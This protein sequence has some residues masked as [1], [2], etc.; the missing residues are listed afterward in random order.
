MCNEMCSSEGFSACGVSVKC[1]AARP[2]PRDADTQGQPLS[3]RGDAGL[4]VL[5]AGQ[6]ENTATATAPLG[7]RQVRKGQKAL[8]CHP[9]KEL[10]DILLLGSRELILELLVH[11]HTQG[12]AL[13]FPLWMMFPPLLV[14]VMV[15]VWSWAV[16]GA[17]LGKQQEREDVQD[18]ER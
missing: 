4:D 10:G 17:H 12:W 16:K 18:L 3:V 14:P 11:V 15:M 6:V 7:H 8:P 2:A 13:P 9:D 5:Q 1:S